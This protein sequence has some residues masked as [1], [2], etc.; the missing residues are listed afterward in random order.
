[1]TNGLAFVYD[2]SGEFPARINGESVLLDRLYQ[3]EHTAT[4]L[5]LI[6][7]HV[8]LTNSALGRQ[9]L[10]DWDETIGSFWTVMPRAALAARVEAEATPEPTRGV[11]D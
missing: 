7:E 4:L 1:M 3:G 5:A 9:L 6:E 2:P 11:A 8:A 10:A